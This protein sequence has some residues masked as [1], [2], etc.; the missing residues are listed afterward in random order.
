M[1]QRHHGYY[2]TIN[3]YD[4]KDVEELQSF[5]S[6]ADYYIY[7][8]EGCECHHSHIHLSVHFK[9]ARRFSAV[10]RFFSKNHN[11]QA[12]QDYERSHM[13]IR[14]YEYRDKKYHLKCKGCSIDIEQH[15]DG[16]QVPVNVYMTEGDIPTNG[17]H[18]STPKAQLVVDA[19]ND[20]KSIDELR[21]MFPAFMMYHE[22]KVK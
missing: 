17:K 15:E 19:I 16:S 22:S 3:Y 10:K 18:K 20:G 1:E 9:N 2:L 12:T 6:T 13:Y 7:G 4:E 8:F 11:I 14:G 21:D 5:V